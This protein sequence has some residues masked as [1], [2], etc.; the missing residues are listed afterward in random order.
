MPV[1]GVGE[2]LG[3]HVIQ[4]GSLV[5][6]D[7]LRFD[8]S[9]GKPLTIAERQ[10]IERRVN[11]EVLRNLEAQTQEMSLDEAQEA[12]AIGLFGEKYGAR[13]RVVS[14]GADSVELCGG[15]HVARAGDIG[16][17]AITHETGIAQGVRRLEAV[18][19]MGAVAH[20]QSLVVMHPTVLA[21]LSFSKPST[22]DV[23]R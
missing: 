19:G 16:L 21:A 23:C 6:P 1:A 10:E 5:A 3:E 2:V 11:A 4:K 8:F 7:R 14:I 12:G 15:T 20:F 17:F 22:Q 18:T 13:V 9:H